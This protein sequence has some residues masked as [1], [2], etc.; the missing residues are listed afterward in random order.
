VNEQPKFA[1]AAASTSTTR[2]DNDTWDLKSSVGTTATMVATARAVASREPNAIIADPFAAPLVRAVGIDVLS[3]LVDG[4]IEQGETGDESDLS[5]QPMIDS[6]AV[7]TRFFDEFFTA[8]ADA[9]IRQAVILASGL[10]SRTYR[11]PWQAGSVVYEIDLPPVLEFKTR[12]LSGL[13][14]EPKATYRPVAVDLR[15]DWLTALRNNGFDATEATAWSAEGLLMYL[16]PDAQDRLFDNITA[17]SAPG[18]RLATDYQPDAAAAVKQRTVNAR[19]WSARG[20]DLD[21]TQLI[22]QGDRSPVPD[23]LAARRWRVSAQSRADLCRIYGLTNPDEN[24]M[25][26]NIAV[27]A[28]LEQAA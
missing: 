21:T 15:D 5:L 19:A 9:G 25:P 12:T 16:P 28:V 2:S 13:G 22:Y 17:L 8:A 24:A 18:S 6:F 26:N 10:D 23:Y 3:Q 14:V 1:P 4:D 20:L 7:R 11:L 27:T